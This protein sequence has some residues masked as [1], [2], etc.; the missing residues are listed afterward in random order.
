MIV[1]GTQENFGQPWRIVTQRTTPI[2]GGIFQ[3]QIPYGL[4]NNTLDATIRPEATGVQ[5]DVT[6][7][8]PLI[9]GWLG[10][11]QRQA[12]RFLQ[13]LDAKVVNR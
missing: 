8:A 6:V 7:R 5:V 9:L 2:S 3:A 12:A 13:A 10:I 1:A 11:P 4:W